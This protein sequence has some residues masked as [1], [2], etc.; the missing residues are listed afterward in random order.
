MSTI[1]PALRWPAAGVAAGLAWGAFARGWMRY[2]STNPEFTWPGTIAI[3]ALAG[4]AGACL[5]TVEG[6]RRGGKG[7]WRRA[8]AV[9]ALLM[10]A[11]PGAVMA[12]T[13]VLGGLALSGRGGRRV[14]YPAALIALAAPALIGSTFTELPHSTFVSL[15]W[16]GLL[17]LG[18][19]V[20]WRAEFLPGAGRQ[21]RRPADR[22]VG[23]PRAGG[24]VR[25]SGR[26]AP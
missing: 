26:M 13:A 11:S 16:Y 9:P 25:P 21:P 5:L 22:S 7:G 23:Q 24:D 10:F 12:P 8:V 19:A 18:L 17:C 14:R 1:V 4:L 20:A 3:V 6:L 15:T 2:I